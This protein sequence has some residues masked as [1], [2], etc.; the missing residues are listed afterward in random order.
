MFIGFLI[1][2]LGIIVGGALTLTILY[3]LAKYLGG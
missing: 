2:L 1:G 3:I